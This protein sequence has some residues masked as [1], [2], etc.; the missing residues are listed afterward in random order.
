MQI[1]V[2]SWYV[3]TSA[4]WVH[5]IRSERFEP[6]LHWW[7]HEDFSCSGPMRW[8]ALLESVHLY[9]SALLKLFFCFI[10]IILRGSSLSVYSFRPLPETP[11]L[12]QQK[13]LPSSE[14][15]FATK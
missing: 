14:H 11:L 12:S 4:V 15:V 3:N 1:I 5:Y 7:H 10:F 6:V 9:S 13:Q 8:E 2:Q